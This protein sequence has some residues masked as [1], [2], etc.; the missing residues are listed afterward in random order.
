MIVSIISDGYPKPDGH[1]YGYKF[2]PMGMVTDGY[3]L[4]PWIWLQTNICNS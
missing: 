2:L 4:Q 3:W 1:M